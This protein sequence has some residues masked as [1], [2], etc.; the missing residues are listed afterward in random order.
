MAGRLLRLFTEQFESLIQALDMLL[1]LRLVISERFLH[2]GVERFL[3]EF[4]K[5]TNNDVFGAQH[6]GELMHKQLTWA[7]Q[8]HRVVSSIALTQTTGFAAGL[9]RTYADFVPWTTCQCLTVWRRNLAVS[10]L[11]WR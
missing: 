11:L 7:P 4:R 10:Q 5:H 2:F 3:A 8:R 6:V 9:V 1:C